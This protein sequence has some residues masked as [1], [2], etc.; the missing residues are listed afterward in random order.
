MAI[1]EELREYTRGAMKE[2]HEKGSPVMR[3]LFYSFP[4]DERCWEVESE[5]MFGGKYL[6]CPVLTPGART[7]KVYFPKGQDWVTFGGKQKYQGGSTAEVACPLDT[8]PVFE[9]L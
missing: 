1:R 2:A 5:Y 7:L 4:A 3:T 8:M 9:K 6:C